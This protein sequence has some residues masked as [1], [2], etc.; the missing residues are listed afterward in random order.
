MKVGGIA[1]AVVLVATL[2]ACGG[3]PSAAG[4]RATDTGLT[5]PIA[6]APSQ[7]SVPFTESWRSVAQFDKDAF[8]DHILG[9][10][11]RPSF[12]RLEPE[13]I[14][15]YRAPPARVS[16]L[17]SFPPRSSTPGSRNTPTEIALCSMGWW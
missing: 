16:T 7:T 8:V 15:E 11:W 2:A 10:A 4:S 1:I 6:T 12:S 5:A 13:F 3:E 17:V 14:V 9:P